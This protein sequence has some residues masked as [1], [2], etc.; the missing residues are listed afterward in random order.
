MGK[1]DYSNTDY[2]VGFYDFSDTLQDYMK[3]ADIAVEALEAGAE[4]FVKDLKKLTKP[5]S[6]INK[7]G[8]THILDT[9]SYRVHRKSKEVTVGWGKYYGVMLEHGA[10][11][12]RRKQPHMM[13]TYESNRKRYEQI[14]L[15][16]LGL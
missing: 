4:A 2:L 11:Q 6:K 5:Y 9:I 1:R 8:Y 15:K 3:V 16:R 7:P 12:M 13:P 10:V 14:M